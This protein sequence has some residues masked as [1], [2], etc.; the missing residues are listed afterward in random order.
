MQF[1]DRDDLHKNARETYFFYKSSNAFVSTLATIEHRKLK[2]LK[3][4]VLVGEFRGLHAFLGFVQNE[5]PT[6]QFE[7]HSLKF[8]HGFNF[9]DNYDTAMSVYLKSPQDVRHFDEKDEQIDG[10]E[11]AG[12]EVVYDVTGDFLD[13]GRFIEG[14]PDNFGSM[15]AG[16]P[17]GRRVNILINLSW[18]ARVTDGVINARCSRIARLIDWLESQQIRTRVTAIESTACNHV[19]ITVKDFDDVLDLNDIAVVSHSD[20]LRRPLFRFKEWSNTVTYGYGQPDSL[21]S[22]VGV[23]K[24]ML[25]PELNNEF[26]VFIDT[27][28]DYEEGINNGFDGLEKW[29]EENLAKDTL[30][31]EERVNMILH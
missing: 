12:K 9:F 16:N 29:F 20:F 4:R 6:A 25:M 28:I 13:I 22:Y 18:S 5:L 17:R 23:D 2:Y 10:G 3:H 21:S 31:T 26:S 24:G 14:D 11:T 30:E 19:E 1:I 7:K 27:R 8:E 15:T